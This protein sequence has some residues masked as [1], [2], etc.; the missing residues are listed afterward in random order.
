MRLPVID[1]HDGELRL[2]SASGKPMPNRQLLHDLCQNL[3]FRKRPRSGCSAVAL[4]VDMTANMIEAA[5]EAIHCY[6]HAPYGGS[7]E[8]A[9]LGRQLIDTLGPVFDG[10]SQR[11]AE[12]LLDGDVKV[13]AYVRRRRGMPGR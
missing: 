12:L 4:T 6:L 1:W 7:D 3:P 10:P 5:A 2:A 13:Y 8:E 9:L 11:R